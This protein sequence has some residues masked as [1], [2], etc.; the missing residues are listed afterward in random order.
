MP[1]CF[2]DIFF[3]HYGK[4]TYAASYQKNTI[5]AEINQNSGHK[6]DG[7]VRVKKM[8]TRIDMTPMVDLAFLLLT[9]FILTSTFNDATIMNLDM[10]EGEPQPINHKNVLNL[11]LAEQNKVYW[12][13]GIDPP[14]SKTDFS[15]KGLRKLLLA[16]RANPH[17]M[18]LIKP[19]DESK[20]EN[21]VDVLD[22]ITIAGIERYA[23]V[24]YTE[25]DKTILAE[26]PVSK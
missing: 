16:H 1:K 21:I 24:D 15:P 26:N 2:R 13:I 8:S 6:S 23:L 22:E 9:F 4:C 25:D 10:R 19:K 3:A 12:W 20:Y 18:V 11:V 17:L 5:M 7:R 14:I